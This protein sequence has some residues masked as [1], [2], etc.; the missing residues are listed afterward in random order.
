MKKQLAM[1]LFYIL[2]CFI[3]LEASVQSISLMN[4]ISELSFELNN[5]ILPLAP[6]TITSI[7]GALNSGQPVNFMAVVQPGE[8]R[9]VYYLLVSSPAWPGNQDYPVVT[10]MT[11]NNSM[12]CFLNIADQK[13]IAMPINNN[14]TVSVTL[15]FPFVRPP[16]EIHLNGNSATSVVMQDSYGHTVSFDQSQLQQLNNVAT[17][18]LEFGFSGAMGASFFVNFNNINIPAAN[19]FVLPVN[20]TVNGNLT[21]QVVQGSFIYIYSKS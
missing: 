16:Y 4:P 15:K 3:D 1:I 7:V 18:S 9:Q 2:S 11:F 5:A 19:S 6:A 14:E 10:P 21:L 20:I 8:D 17:N 12:S 13:P